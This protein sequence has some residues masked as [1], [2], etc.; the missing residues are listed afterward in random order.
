MM[1]RNMSP[2]QLLALKLAEAKHPKSDALTYEDLK[3][4]SLWE[5]D[6]VMNARAKR[7]RRAKRG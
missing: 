4:M 6:A 7:E 2:L 3:R 1:L 5:R